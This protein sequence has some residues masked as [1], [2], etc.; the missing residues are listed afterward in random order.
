MTTQARIHP[1][2]GDERHGT[3]NGYSNLGCC[4]DDCRAVWAKYCLALRHRRTPPPPGD[5]R[6]GKATTYWN[7]RCRCLPCRAAKATSQRN[8]R[9]AVA[10]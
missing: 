4:C 9:L 2:D 1:G 5:E 3:L 7:Y 6:H 10:S 8:R